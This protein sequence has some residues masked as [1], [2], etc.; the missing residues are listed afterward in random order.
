MWRNTGQPVRV[1]MLDGRACFPVIAAMMY[2]SWTTLY[3]AIGGLV[4]FGSIS[5]FGLTVPAMIRL[6]RR[7]VAGR[8]RTAVPAWRRRRFA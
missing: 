3:I 8:V 1:F 5:F 7:W 6:V 4:F 2:W